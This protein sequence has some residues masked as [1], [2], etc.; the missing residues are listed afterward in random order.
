MSSVAGR[1]TPPTTKAASTSSPHQEPSYYSFPPPK[2]EGQKKTCMAKARGWIFLAFLIGFALLS[3]TVLRQPIMDSETWLKDQGTVGL[4]VF[5]VV[6]WVFIM[7]GGSAN[8]IDLISGFVYGG[9][10]GF[11]LSY[12]IKLLSTTL[13]YLAGRYLLRDM[14]MNYFFR[15][16]VWLAAMAKLVEE[17]PWQSNILLRLSIIPAAVKSYGLGAIQDPP[18]P[19]FTCALIVMALLSWVL[20]DLGAKL[21]DPADIFKAKSKGSQ[22]L[23]IIG[24]VSIFLVLVCGGYYGRKYVRQINAEK[25]A[26]MAAVAPATSDDGSGSGTTLEE[27]PEAEEVLFSSKDIVETQATPPVA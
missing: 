7:I 21:K 5:G 15:E 24:I 27:G 10:T 3:G 11:I 13:A 20:A 14:L 17:R 22:I 9:K 8:L 6:S 23:E 16:Y 1:A 2:H 18:L 19:F 12:V 26:E 4:A 25:E